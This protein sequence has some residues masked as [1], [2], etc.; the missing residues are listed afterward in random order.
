MENI[1][2]IDRKRSHSREIEIHPY[3]YDHHLEG[4]AIFPAVEALIV[5]ASAVLTNF[6]E[7]GINK[8]EEAAFPRFLTVPTDA[9]VLAALVD[10]QDDGGSITAALF[11]ELKSKDGNI[12]RNL[13]HARVKFSAIAGTEAESHSFYDLKKLKNGCINVPAHSIYRD[14][15]PF[16]KAYQN[17]IG[18]L[19]VSAS[20]ALAY[21]SGGSADADADPL[22]S[23][24]PLDAVMHAACVW[25][26]RFTG[27][28]SFP[29]GFARRIIY[30]KTKKHDVYLSRIL[31]VDTGGKPLLFDAWIYDL[32]GV[33]YEVVSGIRMQDVSR[34]ERKPPAWISD[35]I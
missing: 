19:S 34:G 18:D 25:G 29:V 4:K 23:P 32:N 14:L 33:L 21:V 11:T 35:G 24:F 20:G 16:G 8:L 17:V 7:A 5:M 6:P 12:R 1:S 13:E 2:P 9:K 26:Q 30:R 22:G 28:V 15:V 10:L 31:P 3:L 27:I